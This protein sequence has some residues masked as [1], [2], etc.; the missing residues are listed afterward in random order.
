MVGRAKGLA[1]V[2]ICQGGPKRRVV[3]SGYETVGV[4]MSARREGGPATVCAYV[5]PVDGL[6]VHVQRRRIMAWSTRARVEV[7]ASCED[8]SR[9][10]RHRPGLRKLLSM[11]HAG[12][13]GGAVLCHPR[14]IS[15]DPI[16]QSAYTWAILRARGHLAVVDPAPVDNATAIIMESDAQRRAW[17]HVMSG[18]ARI[19]IRDE[20]PSRFTGG[21][22]PFGRA[23]QAGHLVDNLE[24]L[25]QTARMQELRE[26]GLS[27]EAIAETLNA[28]QYPTPSG[29]GRWHA[30]TVD[31]VLRRMAQEDR[32]LPMRAWE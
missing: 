18:E 24:H 3:I 14:V 7:R 21:V 28:E 9:A 16:E 17:Q 23:L 27:L 13:V 5:A 30:T 15:D 11:V 8:L 4:I 19:R 25:A 2:K 6:P 29:R 32:N 22:V 20:D 12:D 26:S 1:L 31:R 10:G